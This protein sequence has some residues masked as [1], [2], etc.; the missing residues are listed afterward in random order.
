VGHATFWVPTGRSRGDDAVSAG[1]SFW[2]PPHYFGGY[3]AESADVATLADGN[4]SNFRQ[5]S[6]RFQFVE[7]WPLEGF[8]AVRVLR[9]FFCKL[10]RIRRKWRGQMPCDQTASP[11]PPGAGLHHAQTAK[12]MGNSICRAVLGD[13]LSI[14]SG[15]IACMFRATVMPI[16]FLQHQKQKSN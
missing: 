8:E 3:A 7:T 12:V 14:T 16:H 10:S 9:G 13:A 6:S 5:I 4:P 15:S 1:R 2:F 11:S